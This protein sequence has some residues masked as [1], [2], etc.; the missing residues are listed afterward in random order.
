MNLIF[1]IA[2]AGFI[3]INIYLIGLCI[4]YKLSLSE[5]LS[6]IGRTHIRILKKLILALGFGLRHPIKSIIWIGA[7][8]STIIFS[9]LETL[10]DPRCV[11]TIDMLL[12]SS[13]VLYRILAPLTM[14]VL[15]KLLIAAL[16]ILFVISTAGFYYKLLQPVAIKI[17]YAVCYMKQGSYNTWKSILSNSFMT[18]YKTPTNPKDYAGSQIDEYLKSFFKTETDKDQISF[19]EPKHKKTSLDILYPDELKLFGFYMKDFT[20]E[21]LTIKKKE[22]LKLHHPDNYQD[23]AEQQLH[24][25][26]FIQ[27]NDAYERLIHKMKQA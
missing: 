9:I 24:K 19:G 25:K 11:L 13:F 8:V 26:Q 6:L 12:F 2:A 1:K 22:L 3:I 20:L 16:V 17:W 27:I 4:C 23:T 21:D 10:L 7:F 18:S 15:W 5:T 14:F